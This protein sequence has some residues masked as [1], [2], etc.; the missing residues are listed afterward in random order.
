ME[1]TYGGGQSFI[2]EGAS[3]AD[4]ERMGGREELPEELKGI[5]MKVGQS[6]AENVMW[7]KYKALG[8]SASLLEEIKKIPDVHLFNPAMLVKA[9]GL[10]KNKITPEV[11]SQNSKG[12]VHKLYPVEL[13]RYLKIVEMIWKKKGARE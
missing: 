1:Y 2:D 13:Y 12:D 6:Q 8:V 11:I 4:Y 9:I 3:F 7:Q 10:Y 5:A